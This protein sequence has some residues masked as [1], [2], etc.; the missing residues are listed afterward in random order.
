MT[1]GSVDSLDWKKMDGLL[2]AVV[3][4]ADTHAVLMLGYMDRAALEATLAGGEVT[5]YSRSRGRL[6]RKGETSGNVLRLVAWRADC[7]GDALLIRAR[8]AGPVCHTGAP[9]CFG[10]PAQAFLPRLER[11]VAERSRAAPEQSYTARLLAA[12]LP[13]IA[14]KLGEEGVETALAAASGQR[15]EL[16][17]ESAD[18]LYHLAVLWRAGGVS[19][20]EVEEEL[21]RRHAA[22]AGK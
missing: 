14:Q 3:Q 17:A 15:G 9:S 11:I 13:R 4:D 6:W 2:P 20:A 16:I 8:P 7:D 12:G 22:A 19:L 5:F 10:E 18:L 1:A 21:A